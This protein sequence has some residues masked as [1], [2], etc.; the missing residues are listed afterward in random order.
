MCECEEAGKD[1]SPVSVVIEVFAFLFL[2]LRARDLRT[3]RARIRTQ[4][5]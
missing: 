3:G 1:Q 2:S 5:Q 4:G